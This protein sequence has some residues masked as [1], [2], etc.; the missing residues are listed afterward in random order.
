MEDRMCARPG[1]FRGCVL[2]ALAAS[3]LSFS[4]MA[5]PPNFASNPSVGWYGYSSIFAPPPNRVGPVQQDPAHPYVTNEEFRVTGKQP[6]QRVGDVSNPILQPWAREVIRKRNELVLAGKLVPSPSASCWPVG[7]TL[8][9]LG[10]MTQPMYVVQGRRE[11]ALIL[12]GGN[13]VRHIHLMEKHSAN[14]KTSW[15]GESVG[16]YEGD[17]LL[18]DTIG[19]DDR[20]PVDGFGTPHTS[21]LHVTEHFHLIEDSQVLEVNV[22]VEDP[23]AFTMPW[24]AIQRFRQHSEAARKVPT[25]RLVQLAS[26][27]IQGPL[28]EEIC[29][30]NPHSFF[31]GVPALPI[32]QAAKP[33]F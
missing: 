17:E 20:T 16:H 9:L 8:F 28:Q 11:V 1:N 22:H 31:E 23:G 24:E 12:T 19:L 32:P 6:T 15:Y 21:K 33:D 18:V 29:A 27:T 3:S 2:G 5:E 10:S 7:V 14:L 4:A 25:E 26:G 13:E 30:E